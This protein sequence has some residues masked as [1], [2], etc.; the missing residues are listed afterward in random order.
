[1]PLHPLGNTGLVIRSTMSVL[2]AESC[3]RCPTWVYYKNLPKGIFGFGSI[4]VRQRSVR[5]LY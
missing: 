3:R 5:Y 4:R 1:M 2:P